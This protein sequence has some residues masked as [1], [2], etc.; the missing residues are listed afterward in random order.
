MVLRAHQLQ[1]LKLVGIACVALACSLETLVA[2]PSKSTTR[3]ALVVIWTLPV[4]QDGWKKHVIS[5]KLASQGVLFES[6]RGSGETALEVSERVLTGHAPKAGDSKAPGTWPTMFEYVRKSRSFESWQT[7][8]LTSG[9]STARH[10]HQSAH[11][12]HGRRHAG[13]RVNLAPLFRSPLFAGHAGTAP[14]AASHASEPLLAVLARSKVGGMPRDPIPPAPRRV[15][16]N[17]LMAGLGDPGRRSLPGAMDRAAVLCGG[18]LLERLDEGLIVALLGEPAPEGPASK[19]NMLDSTLEAVG[20]VWDRFTA[21]EGRSNDTAL[22][23]VTARSA[24]SKKARGAR[25]R[26]VSSQRGTLAMI[27]VAPEFKR[28]KVVT[29]GVQT[30]EVCP[31]ICRLFQARTILA[32]AKTLRAAF[33]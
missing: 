18:A 33:K 9:A 17:E 14:P 2:Q 29:A 8:L 16:Q 4:N 24:P 12:D 19:K 3:R 1:V 13:R 27:A 5:R 28:G 6:V 20:L 26:Q 7:W 22:F 10:L 21:D 32:R 15:L 30:L 23:L 11:P 25:R 31:T